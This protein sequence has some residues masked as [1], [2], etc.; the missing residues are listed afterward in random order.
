MLSENLY[1]LMAAQTVRRE[2]GSWTGTWT[3]EWGL[4]GRERRLDREQGLSD[5]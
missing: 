1:I 4:G 3:E 2:E 5:R